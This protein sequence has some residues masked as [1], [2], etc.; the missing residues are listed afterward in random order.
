MLLDIL[1]HSDIFLMILQIMLIATKN[2][3]C[4]RHD[5]AMNHFDG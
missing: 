1:K 5:R 2:I 3:I 4:D